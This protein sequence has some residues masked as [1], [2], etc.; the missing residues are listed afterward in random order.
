M[1][2]CVIDRDDTGLRAL[3]YLQNELSEVVDHKNPTESAAFRQ[4]SASLV[5]GVVQGKS[6][7]RK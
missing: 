1:E 5:M 4:L 7:S 2:L 3:Q 6:E